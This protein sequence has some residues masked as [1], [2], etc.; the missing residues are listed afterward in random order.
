MPSGGIAEWQEYTEVHLRG[1]PKY[2]IARRTAVK[3]APAAPTYQV[4]DLLSHR[5]RLTF[6]SIIIINV[7]GFVTA[8]ATWIV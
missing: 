3:V 4:L 5:I 8:L 2:G 6:M 7:K 1:P